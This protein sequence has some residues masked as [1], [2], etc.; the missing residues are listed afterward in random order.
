VEYINK[1]ELVAALVKAKAE[2]GEIKKTKENPFFHSKYA[3]LE[4]VNAA[5]N[6]AL[7]KHGLVVLQPVSSEDDRL[8]VNTIL[9]HEGGQHIESKWEVVIPGN[10]NSRQQAEGAAVTYIRRYAISALLGIAS[11]DDD[12]GNTTSQNTPQP[13]QNKNAPYQYQAGKDEKACYA[14]AKE[15]GWNQYEIQ[16]FFRNNCPTV[17]V[18]GGEVVF[19][20]V[21]SRKDYKDEN[22][23]LLRAHL[24]QMK[25][26]KKAPSSESDLLDQVVQVMQSDTINMTRYL[27]VSYIADF[28]S[29][30]PEQN[31]RINTFLDKLL[32]NPD[33]QERVA[34]DMNRAIEWY[35]IL[36]PDKVDEMV[37][38]LAAQD[39][40]VVG[41]FL[42]HMA[43]KELRG[44]DQAKFPSWKDVL[45]RSKQEAGEPALV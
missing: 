35:N 12:D 4:A 19:K 25:A 10:P 15:M 42:E 8:Y 13:Q 26:N 24:Q 1:T 36:G 34:K 33:M 2:F 39:K 20:K 40:E 14:I 3:D 30:T 22:W 23:K 17:N 45:Q 31:A 6:P 9:L 37:H 38:T 41:L 16:D 11:E 44:V 43:A 18:E 21:S 27:E 28:E 29:C 5:V 7:A 32:N